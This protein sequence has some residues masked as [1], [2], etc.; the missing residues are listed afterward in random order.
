MRPYRHT[1]KLLSLSFAFLL[2]GLFGCSPA[3]EG[4]QTAA[5]TSDNAP[6]AAPAQGGT[7]TAPA[8]PQ[9][10]P[11]AAAPG[12][13]P[14]AGPEM[15]PEKIPAVVARVNGQEIKKEDLVTEAQRMQMQVSVGMGRRMPATQDF[16]RKVLDNLIAQKLLL[17]DAKAKGITANEDEVKTQITELRSRLGE[18]G[19]KKALDGEKMTEQDLLQE[20]RE[21]SI[22]KKYLQS[23]IKEAPVSDQAAKAFYDQNQQQMKRPEQAHLRHILVRVPEGATPEQKQQ[24]RAKADGVLA[25][26]K[27]GEDFAKLAQENSDDPSSKERGGDLSWVTPGQTVES[28]E[29]AAFALKP[30]EVSPVVESRFG[31]HIIQLL[32]H[33]P[34]GVLPFEQVKDRI[35]AVLKDKQTSEAVRA[36]V[37]T[38][39]TKAKVETFI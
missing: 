9:G 18:D 34:A 16:Y 26:V 2:A 5:E 13:A 3:S 29:K 14:A 35:G 27:A 30:N 6:A 32:E 31:Y 39:R 15:A 19:F 7:A 21:N 38:L 28:F 11:G 33:R 36:H 4:E 17:D 37:Q 22:V 1:S 25:R 10:Q 8:V 20:L 24:A 23:T 12:Q